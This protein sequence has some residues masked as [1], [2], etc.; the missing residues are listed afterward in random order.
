[1]T[2]PFDYIKDASYDKKNLMRDTDNDALCESEYVPW[3]A[4]ISFSNH[5]DTILHANL[6]NVNWHIDNRPQYEYYLNAVRKKRRYGW[7]KVDK[8]SDLELVRESYQC[9]NNKARDYLKILSREQL[10]QLEKM[11]YEGGKS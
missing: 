5:P 7:N 6:M 10:D 4:N 9:G 2:S 3:L 1:M 11:R 8:I